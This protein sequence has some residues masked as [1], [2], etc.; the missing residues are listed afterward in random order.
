MNVEK[1]EIR[2]TFGK[3][4]T[5]RMQN[6]QNGLYIKEL[7]GLDP[8]KSNIVTTSFAKRDGTQ[9]QASRRESR[10]LKIKL[11]FDPDFNTTTV[12]SL[13]QQLYRF[14]MTKMI[15]DV[16]Y[17]LLSGLVVEVTGEVETFD[18]PRMVQDPEATIG[19][20]CFESDFREAVPR[21]VEHVSTDGS[22]TGSGPGVLDYRGSVE[23][24]FVFRMAATR[25]WEEFT[26]INE[27]EDGMIR[28]LE[29]S[30]PMLAGDIL[31]ISTVTG[32]KGAWRTR[33][34]L[35]TSI[36]NGVSPY[37]DWVNFFPGENKLSLVMEGA[38]ESFTIEYSEK[39]G[40]I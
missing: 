25:N 30:E 36:L 21:I 4:L 23:T 17:Y 26:F 33:G 6:S 22:E 3:L 12:D 11:G 37:S 5:L 16:R 2:T 34:A 19:I 15:V 1:I 40:G 9:R 29:F 35:R 20:Y 39:Y 8:T 28:Q 27:T 32:E 31:E 24:G 13:R 38:P 14:F 10:D 18:S 7:D